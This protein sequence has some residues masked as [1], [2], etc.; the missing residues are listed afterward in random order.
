M[1]DPINDYDVRV[2]RIMLA[3]LARP[4]VTD[5]ADC[6]DRR[7]FAKTI[8]ILTD[9]RNDLAI[10]ARRDCHHLI[11]R[12][13]ARMVTDVQELSNDPTHEAPTNRGQD[14]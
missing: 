6:V 11:R 12:G 1:F 9:H 5:V 13:H 4:G 2:L 14:R 8:N 10:A 3:F 7:G